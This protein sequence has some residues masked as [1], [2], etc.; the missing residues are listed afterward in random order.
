MTSPI[1]VL[2][3]DDHRLVRDGIALIISSQ[4]DMKVVGFAATSDE[5]VA[6][7]A[8]F[9]PDITLMDLRLGATSGLSAI[10]AIRRNA[11]D[12]RIIVLTMY[13]GDE[14]IHQALAAGATTY[15]LKDG[16]SDDLIGTIRDVHAGGHPLS[17][18]VKAR[19]EAR[20]SRPTLTSREVQVLKLVARGHRN[21]E[22]GAILGI[23]EETVPVHLKSIFIKLN[24]NDRMA[25]VNVALRRGI[26]HL[27]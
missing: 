27:E 26:V 16:L 21:K 14:D 2:C 18:D 15:L 22:V 13:G 24:V 1:R 19:L 17:P 5:A 20:A 4:P 6:Q 10:H 23:S 9:K 25:A 12:A 3:V 11:P 7:F 8:R